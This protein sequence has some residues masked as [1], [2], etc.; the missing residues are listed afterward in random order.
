MDID[1]ESSEMPKKT[2]YDV[3]KQLFQRVWSEDDEIGVLKGLLEYL[4]KQG[5]D[6]VGDLPDLLNFIKVSLQV[7]FSKTQLS[8]KIRRLKKRYVNNVKKGKY[9][10]GRIFM[11]SHEQRIF[12]LS[13]RIWGGEANSVGFDRT[14]VNREAMENHYN[15]NELAILDRAKEGWKM[16]VEPSAGVLKPIWFN[17]SDRLSDMKEK[18]IKDELELIT[19]P[20]KFELEE[21]WKQL[22]VAEME[23]Y[24]K[25]VDLI[26]EQTK[27]VMEAMR[28]SGR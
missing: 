28:S 17:R 14:E 25:R 15:K 12:E 26:M 2:E 5:A 20:K 1:S 9:G 22:R 16:E 13:K 3:K 21:K 19:V 10:K 8:D 11:K 4:A 24:L 27:L 23:L 7:D 6:P 18:I